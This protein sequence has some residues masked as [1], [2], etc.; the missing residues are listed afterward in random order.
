MTKSLFESQAASAIS[1]KQAENDLAKA[2][3][4]LARTSA[5]IKTLGVD[6][7]GEEL[8]SL[9]PVRSPINGTVTDRKV[10]EGQYE[11]AD[12]NALLTIADLSSVWIVADLFE[13]DLARV[14]VGQKAE[15]STLAYPDDHVMGQVWRIS[16]VVDP[17]TRTVK[18]RILVP[19]P[20]GRLKPEMFASILLFLKDAEPALTLPSR[21][22]FIEGGRHFVFLERMP[23]EFERRRVDLVPAP[24]GRI[25]VQSGLK[26]GDKVVSEDVMLLR[27]QESS[28]DP[29]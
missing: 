26:A 8:T 9:I 20:Q 14:T 12:S 13:R 19:N 23:G 7:K 2:R 22:A 29:K 6:L 18:V 27:A 5:A 4:R 15:L 17:V 3:G 21:A 1:L 16:D 10:T 28:D 11:T 25:R 24:E